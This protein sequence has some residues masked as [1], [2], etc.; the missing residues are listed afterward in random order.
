[1]IPVGTSGPGPHGV[2]SAVGASNGEAPAYGCPNCGVASRPGDNFCEACGYDLRRA[3]PPRPVAERAPRRGQFAS[4]VCRTCRTATISADGWCEVCGRA[5]NPRDS[6]AFDIG[7]AAGMSDRG[8]RHRRNEDAMAIDIVDTPH[9]G[10]IVVAVV[11]DGVSSS[12]RP[13]DASATAASTASGALVAA[14]RGGAGPEAATRAAA[15]AAASAVARLAGPGEAEGNA[16]AC[17]YVSAVVTP[18]TV[19]IG[20]VGDSRAY[21]LSVDGTAA[22]DPHEPPAAAYP[23]PEAA[24]ESV[25]IALPEPAWPAEPPEESESTIRVPTPASQLTEDDSWAARMVACGQMTEAQAFADS[26]AHAIVSWLG[27]DAGEVRA[28]VTT[29]R[30]NTPGA[31]LLCSDGL[32]N[33]VQPA[34]ALSAFA[35][36]HGLAQPMRAA[37]ELTDYALQCG[38]ADNITVALVPFPPAAHV[39]SEPKE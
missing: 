21:W 4:A 22:G 35:L 24:R 27:A 2:T 20:W 10:P 15:A 26:R 6:M 17:T 23:V 36:P 18:E 11:C 12:P 39:G 37:Q 1:M 29:L 8:L 31:V 28:R 25:R 33:Y 9:T 3:A 30:P 38:G 5:Y 14:L 16:P 34:Q 7:I 13:D 19:T 32:W